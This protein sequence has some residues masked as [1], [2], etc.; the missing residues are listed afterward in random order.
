MVIN[1]N[2]ILREKICAV[3]NSIRVRN[4]A[5]LVFEEI[6]GWIIGI[7]DGVFLEIFSRF[8]IQQPE[9]K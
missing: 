4:Y 8:S 6:I 1:T 5:C 7:K 2:N 3:F 9:K